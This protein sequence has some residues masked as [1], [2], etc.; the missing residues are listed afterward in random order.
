MGA[1]ALQGCAKDDGQFFKAFGTA[2]G[3]VESEGARRG[4]TYVLGHLTL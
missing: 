3:P 1:A 4:G 2:S